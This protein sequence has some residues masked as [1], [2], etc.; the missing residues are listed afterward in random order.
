MTCTALIHL[1]P[2]SQYAKTALIL[3]C[4]KIT[5]GGG[6]ANR[7]GAG[8]KAG[9]LPRL[10]K[11]CAKTQVDALLLP[12]RSTLISYAICNYETTGLPDLYIITPSSSDQ[13]YDGPT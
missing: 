12:I 3:A 2:L 11:M 1:L 6:V 5:Q 4:P 9:C 13:K 8:A 7:D 10:A